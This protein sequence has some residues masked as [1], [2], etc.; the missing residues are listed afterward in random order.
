MI[1]AAWLASALLA[2]VVPAALSAQDSTSTMARGCAVL[3]GIRFAANWGDSTDAR[4]RLRLGNGRTTID[5]TFRFD[6]AEKSWTRPSLDA[7]VAAGA[8][9]RTTPPWHACVGITLAMQQPTIVLRG[10]RGELHLKVDL[11]ALSRIQGSG[12]G[13]STNRTRR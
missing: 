11:T 10:V 3:N 8:S 2:T 9:G 5:T 7:M 6:V 13:D 12:L 1:R 4:D